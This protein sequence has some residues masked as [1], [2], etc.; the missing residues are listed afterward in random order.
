[1]ESLVNRLQ[2]VEVVA[3]EMISAG[4]SPLQSAVVSRY[5]G[6]EHLQF[7]DAE[8]KVIS[9]TFQNPDWYHDANAHYPLTITAINR[10]QSGELDD[11]Y[12]TPDEN[13]VSNQ[14]VARRAT[15]PIYLAVKTEVLAIEAALEAGVEKDFYISDLFDILRNIFQ[16]SKVDPA[17][18]VTAGMQADYT[19]YSYLL[20]VITG[21]LEALSEKAVQ[22]S[23]RNNSAA[24][25]E[26]SPGRVGSDLLRTW[27]FCIWWTMGEP[28]KVDPVL[29]DRIVGRYF[30]FLFTLGCQPS[31]I[32]HGAAQ[33]VNS[34]N[35]WRDALL[36]ELK[37][38][39]PSPR[40]EHL[41][42]LKRVFKSLDFGKPFISDAYDW[43]KTQIPIQ[44]LPD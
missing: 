10:I 5:G 4:A 32:L 37:L 44:F 24:P 19:P 35:R 15:C 6:I 25:D 1:L 40:Q 8:R 17:F 21:D 2:A 23:V 20:E 13:Y 29:R 16:R 9:A 3:R 31:E 22:Q 14:G 11:A 7:T 34:L 33:T 36:K 18:N 41:N 26:A 43:L 38:H 30:R 27:S 39:F 42:A 28:G 12:N